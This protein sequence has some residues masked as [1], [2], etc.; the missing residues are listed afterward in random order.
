MRVHKKSI[1]PIT[2]CVVSVNNEVPVGLRLSCYSPSLCVEYGF[3][4]HIAHHQ[5]K[6][7]SQIEE[8]PTDYVNHVV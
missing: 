4:I 3:F 2:L 7:P 6:W 8:Q 5:W 1:I